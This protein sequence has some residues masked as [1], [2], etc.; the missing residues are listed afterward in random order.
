MFRTEPHVYHARTLLTRIE[1]FPFLDGAV[2]VVLGAVLGVLPHAVDAEL[3]FSCYH[4]PLVRPEASK[5]WAP[6]C[7]V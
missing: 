2:L 4:H 3:G 6:S 5:L 7:K 1:T